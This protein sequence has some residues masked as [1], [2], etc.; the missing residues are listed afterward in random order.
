MQAAAKGG[1]VGVVA[2]YVCSSGAYPACFHEPANQRIPRLTLRDRCLVLANRLP[3]PID[4]GW[5]RRTFHVLRGLAANAPVTLV[6]FHA[7]GTD[8]AID[9]LEAAIPGIVVKAVPPPRFRTL[10]AAILGLVTET[11]FPMWRV[12]SRRFDVAVKEVCA[13]GDIAQVVVEVAYMF[14]YAKRMGGMYCT[15]IDT[16]NIDSL[17]LDRYARTMRG[18]RGWYARMT[19]RKLKAQ[20]SDSFAAAGQ[21]WVC[22]RKEADCLE[23]IVPEASVAVV[24]NGVDTTYF[25]PHNVR[26]HT[27]PNARNLLFFG[28][29]DYYPNADGIRYFLESVLPRIWARDATVRFALAGRGKIDESVRRMASLDHRIRIHGAVPDLRPV[30]LEAAAVVVPLRSG[31]GTRLKILEALSMGKP[32]VSTTIGMEGL[33]LTPGK[34]LEVADGAQ[35]FADRTFELLNDN[36]RA[37]AL[38]R[39]GR[40]A[41]V[42][43]YDWSAIED[44]IGGIIARVH[45]EWGNCQGRAQVEER[46]T[47]TTLDP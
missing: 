20:E 27:A 33:D 3:Y 41:V 31:G 11:P 47:T 4:D 10:R 19:A 16:H 38:G 22:S 24:P 39:S 5:K 9:D 28:R 35:E 29:L 12:D 15:I 44:Q 17:V 25:S 37:E 45:E 43:R 32:V 1:V 6:A 26:E 8:K 7:P 40:D 36:A 13:R 21:V 23:R 14:P 18:V 34:H 46:S 30:I 42:A 2:G